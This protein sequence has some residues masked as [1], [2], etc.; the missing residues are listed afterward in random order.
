MEGKEKRFLCGQ[1]L[2]R[3]IY[4]QQIYSL[5]QQIELLNELNYLTQVHVGVLLFIG[6]FYSTTDEDCLVNSSS[7][8]LSF[9][10]KLSYWMSVVLQF[11]MIK[12]C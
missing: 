1:M 6:T 3:D 7:K 9:E 12:V 2:Q 8:Q 11:I 10:M 4:E 5:Q